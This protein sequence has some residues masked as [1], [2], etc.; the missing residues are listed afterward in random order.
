MTLTKNGSDILQI[1]KDFDRT[2]NCAIMYFSVSTM[3]FFVVS[4]INAISRPRKIPIYVPDIIGQDLLPNNAIMSIYMITDI[5]HGMFPL[6]FA[7]MIGFMGASIIYR[8]IGLI[9]KRSEFMLSVLSIFIMM[10]AIAPSLIAPGDDFLRAVKNRDFDRVVEILD[11]NGCNNT[12]ESLYLLAQISAEEG[13]NHLPI[14][15]DVIERI[16][17][18][19]SGFSPDS[20]IV[21]HIRS[22]K[23]EETS[24]VV[25]IEDDGFDTIQYSDWGMGIFAFFSS[26]AFILGILKSF[27]LRSIQHR[28]L[29]ASLDVQI[30]SN[31]KEG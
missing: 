28:L 16:P 7:S 12:P 20:K 5:F 27:H 30:M 15:D 22:H 21:S 11:E 9:S 31:R 25:L 8:S 17:T 3:F 6:L 10:I 4:F 26:V 13:K 2:K 23:K 19:S 1:E 24:L 29:L 14:T 18:P